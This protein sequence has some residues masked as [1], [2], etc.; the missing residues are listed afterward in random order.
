MEEEQAEPQS[1]R[2]RCESPVALDEAVGMAG[3]PQPVPPLE[4]ADMAGEWFLSV[5]PTDVEKI[6]QENSVPLHIYGATGKAY[7]GF[8]ET[9]EAADDRAMQLFRTDRKLI[10]ANLRLLKIQFSHKGFSHYAMNKLGVDHAFATMFHKNT[11]RQDRTGT[12]WGAWS[13]YGNL[14]LLQS[15]EKGNLLIVTE[16]VD[17]MP[18]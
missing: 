6:T 10:R 12:D 5:Y 13:F 15:D 17:R 11:Y 1:K 4:A 8:R 18:A 16:W 7:I 9:A 2:S 14:P 3:S